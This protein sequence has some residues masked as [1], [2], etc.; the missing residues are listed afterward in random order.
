MKKMISALCLFLCFSLLLVCCGC[1]T[2]SEKPFMGGIYY[3]VGPDGNIKQQTLNFSAETGRFNFGAPE[4]YSSYLYEG[5][6]SVENGILSAT[7]TDQKYIFR[8]EVTENGLRFLEKSSDPLKI[9]FI[10]I[11]DGSLFNLLPNETE[12]NA[13][14]AIWKIK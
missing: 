5:L 14:G 6:Y 2:A 4:F 12:T 11:Q 10:Q 3:R 8:F 7:T 9:D 1:N 13:G